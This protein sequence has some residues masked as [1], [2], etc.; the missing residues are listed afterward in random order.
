MLT[1][2]Q[3]AAI[4][5]SD[6]VDVKTVERDYVLSHLIQR[7]SSF[8]QAKALAFKGG[9]ALR[10][11][12]FQSFRYSADIDFN[13]D[14][15]YLSVNEVL[16]LISEA[17]DQVALELDL[18]IEVDEDLLSYVGPRNQSEPEK[19]KLDI[20]EDEISTDEKVRRGLVIRYPD[21]SEVTS[22]PTYSLAETT[23]EK[24]RCVMQRLQCRDLFDIHRLLA[25]EQV[26]PDEAWTQFQDK[27]LHRGL[28]PELFRD[29]WPGR[30]DQYVQRWDTE[31]KRY[32]GSVPHFNQIVRETER[33]LR[34][35]LAR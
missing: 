9:T 22:L 11:V 28:D 8:E 14:T 15:R 2:N 3:L 26:D 19:V 31:M 12:H 16:G 17:A 25:Q 23:A 7:I 18:S 34:P 33:A 24:L 27:A 32:T 20:T 10:L 35:I 6:G 30:V 13:A 29:R 1:L 21:Q 5:E 4:A